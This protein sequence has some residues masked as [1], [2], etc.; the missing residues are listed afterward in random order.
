MEKSEMFHLG[1]KEF[2]SQ[3]KKNKGPKDFDSQKKTKKKRSKR[4]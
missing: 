1:P 4:F 2:D 3:K